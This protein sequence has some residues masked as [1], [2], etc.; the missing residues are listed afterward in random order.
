MN[1]YI[2]LVNV[3]L[4]KPKTPISNEMASFFAVTNK[5]FK[6]FYTGRRGEKN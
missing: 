1:V 5:S 4:P 6:S 3:A 2:L